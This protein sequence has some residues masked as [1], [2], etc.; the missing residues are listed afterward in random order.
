MM[1]L[2]SKNV[3]TKGEVLDVNVTPAVDQNSVPNNIHSDLIENQRREELR[4]QQAQE[5]QLARVK[6][7]QVEDKQAQ[8]LRV[9]Q[10]QRRVD[11]GGKLT[12]SQ[13]A[14]LGRTN[15][16]EARQLLAETGNLPLNG[17]GTALVKPTFKAV[18]AAAL[19]PVLPFAIG[20]KVL[21]KA[22]EIPFGPIKP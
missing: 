20:A 6:A 14:E 13:V 10:L 18:S 11:A 9:E 17:L 21:G 5:Q 22:L 2:V 12:P 15:S 3:T 19:G 8:D 1:I 7:Q 4:I 16:P